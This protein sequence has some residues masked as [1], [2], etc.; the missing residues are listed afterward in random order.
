MS[1]GSWN[2]ERTFYGNRISEIKDS[3]DLYV[4]HVQKLCYDDIFCTDSY[5]TFI[6]SKM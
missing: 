2:I 5:H 3:G 1:S 6:F 4:V